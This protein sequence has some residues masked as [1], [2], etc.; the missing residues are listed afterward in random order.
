MTGEVVDEMVYRTPGE[1]AVS[2]EPEW[3]TVPEF[4][5]RMGIS[6]PSAYKAVRRDKVPGAFSMGK[7]V[8]VNWTYFVAT[9]GKTSPPSSSAA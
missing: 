6:K 3:I 8:R 1:L 2:G 7:L 5:R 9:A 4:A